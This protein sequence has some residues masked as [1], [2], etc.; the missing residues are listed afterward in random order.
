MTVLVALG[1][2][3]A[4]TKNLAAQGNTEIVLVGLHDAGGRLSTHEVTRI[5]NRAG[6]DNQPHILPGNRAVLY[7]VIDSAGQTDIFR[8]D[9]ESRGTVSL[10][11][12]APESEYSATLMPSG[13]RF[14]VIRVERDSTQRL[15]SFRL[16]GSDPRIVLNDVKPV[17]YHAWI[18]ADRVAV[19]VLGNPSTLQL[20]DVR[21]GQARVLA[22]NIGRSLNRIPGRAAIS[23]VHRDGTDRTGW[24]TSWDAGSGATQRIVQA[25]PENEYHAWTPSGTLISARGSILYQFTPGR[26]TGWVQVADLSAQGVTGISRLA[27]SPDGTLLALVAEM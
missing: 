20:A 17:G 18:D 5:T 19:F 23:F 6:Y 11:R 1:S 25:M 2:G 4:A 12:S 21:T 8:Y 10:T 15:W 14:S 26:D 24:I 3:V 7:T 22:Q 13:D 9:I 27:V 16:D